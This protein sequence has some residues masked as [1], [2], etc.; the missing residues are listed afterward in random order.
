MEFVV[1]CPVHPFPARTEP[2][3]NSGPIPVARVE[4]AAKPQELHLDPQENVNILLVDDAPGKLMAHESVLEDLGETVIKASSGREALEH[5]LKRD[6]AVILLDVN[7]PDM[8]G[9]ETAAMIRQHPSFEH[10]PIL[11][12]TAY[13]TTDLDRLKGYDMGAADYIFLPVIPGVL[14][15]KV[16]VFVQLARQRRIIERQAQALATQNEQQ[17]GQIQVI[18]ELNDKLQSANEELEAFSYSVSHDLRSPLRAMQGYA[19][20]L[21]EDFGPALDKDA[22]EYLRR[23]ERAALRMDALVRDV[24]AYTRLAK[25]DVQVAPV[26]LETM[27]HEI[28]RD[29]RGLTQARAS[30]VV[31]TP[32]SPVMGHEACLTQ[33]LSNLLENSAKFMPPDRPPCI[34][35][36]TEVREGRVRIWVEDN[37]IGIDPSHHARIFQMFGRVH[38]NNSYEGTGMGLTIV[39]KAVERMGGVIGLESVLGAGSRFW[40]ELP[41]PRS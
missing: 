36:R 28:V 11:F 32:L 13:N 26:D 1:E 16:R 14:K 3:V 39:K 31:K 33:C 23:I 41:A 12:I 27:V 37:G 17:Q 20:A 29:S 30:V 22:C 8:D 18:Q 15:A 25:A 4:V 5:L 2:E 40:I 9:F 19:H 35:V 6:F 24:L 34:T 7:M 21:L 10:T 38:H